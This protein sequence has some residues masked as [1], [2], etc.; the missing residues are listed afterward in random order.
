M[1]H[2]SNPDAATSFT[3]RSV[4]QSASLSLLALLTYQVE[5]QLFPAMLESWK[6][7]TGGLSW[8]IP[9]WANRDP[10]VRSSGLSIAAGLSHTRAGRSLV[11]ACFKFIPGG[12]WNSAL[13]F[14]FSVDEPDLVKLNAVNLL[15]VMLR[16]DLQRSDLAL[17]DDVKSVDL[18]GVDALCAMLDQLGFYR[19]VLHVCQSFDGTRHS[20]IPE[21]YLLG[22][23]FG[24]C[25]ALIKL[26]G[27]RAVV[28]L[29]GLKFF[30]SALHVCFLVKVFVQHSPKLPDRLDMFRDLFG[31]VGQ[32]VQADEGISEI[33]SYSEFFFYCTFTDGLFLLP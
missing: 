33:I 13:S 17:R 1:A 7:E 6:D 31:M 10:L 26:V 11:I 30:H 25:G 22:A 32:A 16:S 3:G 21:D 2:Q 29:K 9:I 5:N 23:V 24:L 8:L 20:R 27:R 4:I 19:A 12:V 28:S 15:S 18:E 14:L